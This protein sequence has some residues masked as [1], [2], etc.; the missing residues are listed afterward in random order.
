MVTRN[1]KPAAASISPEELE[2]LEDDA[3]LDEARRTDD[4]QRISYRGF[5]RQL[6]N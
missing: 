5:K 3:A 4:G 1:G 6:D 2:E